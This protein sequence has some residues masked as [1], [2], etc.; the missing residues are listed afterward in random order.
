MKRGT[1]EPT[2]R[3]DN[4]RLERATSLFL[5]CPRHHGSC[6][7]VPVRYTG[8]RYLFVGRHVLCDRNQNEK[9][10]WMT[11][12]DLTT[13][14]ILSYV[15]TSCPM[16]VALMNAYSLPFSPSSFILRN[17]QEENKKNK[18]NQNPERSF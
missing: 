17:K 1:K 4:I 14:F 15:V 2:V 10:G 7:L 5:F 13:T 16:H 12:S 18:K 9:D 8:N 11:G 6:F 3:R